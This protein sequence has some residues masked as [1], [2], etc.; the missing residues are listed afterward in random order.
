MGLPRVND[1]VSGEGP[2]VGILSAFKLQPD[3]AWLVIACDFP[4]ADQKA[5]SHLVRSRDPTANATAY[6]HPDGTLEPLFAIWEP[7]A[8]A[9]LERRFREGRFSPREALEALKAEP[10]PAPDR[11]WL[12]NVNGPWKQRDR[13]PVS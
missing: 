9:L 4:F 13:C 7:S 3:T 1:C 2:G 8:L 6:V 11:E 5:V 12:V 10:V